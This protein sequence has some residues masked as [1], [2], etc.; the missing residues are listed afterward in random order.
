MHGETLKLTALVSSGWIPV[1][2]Q[3]EYPFYGATNSRLS[4]QQCFS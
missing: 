1:L 4:V 3:V 2:G